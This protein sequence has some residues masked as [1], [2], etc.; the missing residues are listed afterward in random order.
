MTTALT[1]KEVNHENISMMAVRDSDGEIFVGIKSICDGLG[2]VYNGQMERINRDE[3]LSQ[4]VR[5]IRIPS[6]GGNQSTSMIA[7]S[8]LPFFL[9]GIKSSMV[10]PE[11][12]DNIINFKLKAKDVLAQAF[13]LQPQ[14]LNFPISEQTILQLQSENKKLSDL[15]HSHCYKI[16]NLENVVE[17]TFNK[18]G[19]RKSPKID[20]QDCPPLFTVPYTINSTPAEHESPQHKTPTITPEPTFA[21]LTYQGRPITS[22]VQF[23]ALRREDKSPYG[24][25]TYRTIYNRMMSKDRWIRLAKKYQKQNNTFNVNKATLIENN[26]RL[27]TLYLKTIKKMLKELKEGK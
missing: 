23:L 26:D 27:R 12:K 10:K 18:L 21:T 15:V 22:I 4:G 13:L 9:T 17:Q 11:I 3:L 24:V 20:N 5:K 25:A 7:I 6:N 14:Y 2:I 1:V 8:F 16:E 19:N